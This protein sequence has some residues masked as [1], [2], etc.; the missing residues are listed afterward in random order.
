MDGLPFEP[1]AL[2]HLPVHADLHKAECI[3]FEKML[4]W[5]QIFVNGETVESQVSTESADLYTSGSL[6]RAHEILRDYIN[7]FAVE[8]L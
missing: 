8:M 6:I 7:N 3:S 2:S 5:A 1:L 4:I